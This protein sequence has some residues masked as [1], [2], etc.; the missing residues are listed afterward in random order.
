MIQR[1]HRLHRLETIACREVNLST[2]CMFICFHFGFMMVL[3]R[4]LPATVCTQRVAS[5]LFG[6]KNKHQRQR[7]ERQ[8]GNHSPTFRQ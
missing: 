5:A 3:D 4:F 6:D 7:R 1:I 8:D 2:V